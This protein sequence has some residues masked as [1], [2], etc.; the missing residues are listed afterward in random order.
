MSTPTVHA[1]RFILDGELIEA[2]APPT[3]TVLQYLRESLGRSGSKEGCAEGDCGACTV[4]LG[5]PKPGGVRYSAINSCIRFLPTID[6]CE[7][8]TTESLI[9]PDGS[10]HP[11][12]QALVNAHAS[13]CGF[14]TPG[15][16]MSLFAL[17]LNDPEPDREAVLDA[18]SGNLCRCTGYRPIIEAGLAMHRLAEPSVWSRRASQSEAIQSRLAQIQRDGALEMAAS[19]GYAAPVELA[20]LAERYRAAP[21]ALLLAGGTDVGLWVTKQYRSLPPLLYIGDVRE[22]KGVVERDGWLEIGAAVRLTDAFSAIVGHYPCL[23]EL[24]QRFAS[25]PVRNSGTLCGNI[26]N[27]SPIGDS[28][29]VLIALGA[30]VRLRR[31]TE[32]R[33][34]PLEALYLGYQKKALLPG[35]FVVSVSVPLPKPAETQHVASYKISKRFEQDI[36]CVCAAFAV[37]IEEGRVESARIAYGGVGATPV[38]ARRVEGALI[39]QPWDESTCNRARALFAEDFQPISDMRASASYRITVAANLLYRF[40]L[41]SIGQVEPLSVRE[42]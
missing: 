29:P 30:T 25:P 17:Y 7:V 9:A 13:Q 22:L 10:L 4:V 15:F 11:V 19:P 42:L 21:D 41:E 27:G 2:N 1:P 24:A 36:S 3:T 37:R 34:L 40:F 23:H 5:E 12:Q 16:V 14:C 8:V 31:G 39:G 20:D 38:R 18:L 32:E 26:A 33:S 35:E 6:G 28:M